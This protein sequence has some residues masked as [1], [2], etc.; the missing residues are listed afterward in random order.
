VIGHHGVTIAN[1]TVQQFVEGVVFIDSSDGVLR[2]VHGVEQRHVGVFVDRSR[3]VLIQGND[4]DRIEFSGI[5]A[6]RS[7]RLEIDHNT[8]SAS[9]GGI[10][11]RSSARSRV[12]D[13]RVVGVGCGGIQLY[14]GSLHNTVE[15]NMVT[16]NGCDGISVW[17][18]SNGNVVSR[19]TVRRN[20]AGV[21]VGASAH[22]RVIANTATANR[23]TGIYL[24]GAD[25]NLVAHNAVTGNGDGSEAGIHVL[26]DD[27]GASSDGNDL[28]RN[29]VVGS[30][31]DGIL[32]ERG[33]AR[34]TLTS[35]LVFASSDD[36]IDVSSPG[37]ALARNIA[38]H[39]GELGIDAVVGVVDGGGNRAHGNGDP[40]ECV[41]ISCR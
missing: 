22:N 3:R 23:F 41:N 17:T 32:V 8:V 25:E 20:D 37:S 35:N 26:A 12:A 24:F 14:D 6:T 15:L 10:A 2:D 34:T 19:N 1:G 11:L 33:S 21:G 7:S 38:N 5:F 39:N 18:G 16:G 29:I 40:A 27:S 31:G 4:F 28:Q 36:G 9:G 30:T 13:N